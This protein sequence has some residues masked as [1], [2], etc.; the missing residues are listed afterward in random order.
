MLRE[1]DL[2]VSID[3]P[4]VDRLVPNDAVSIDI[5]ISNK[6]ETSADST[7]IAGAFSDSLS[8]VRWTRTVTQ[9]SKYPASFTL[10]ELGPDSGER[11]TAVNDKEFREPPFNITDSQNPKSEFLTVRV[12]DLNNDGLE[13]L[14]AQNMNAAYPRNGVVVFRSA[15]EPVE[16]DVA[17]IDGNNGF[18]TSGGFQDHAAVGDVNGDSIDDIVFGRAFNFDSGPISVVF[19]RNGAFPATVDLANIDQTIG[20]EVDP[21]WFMDRWAGTLGAPGDVNGDGVN[22]ILVGADADIPAEP[23]QS[24]ASVI[25]GRADGEFETVEQVDFY[26]T[27]SGSG[28][29][30]NPAGDI[31]ADGID[32]FVIGGSNVSYVLFGSRK[33]LDH[34]SSLDALDG[35]RGFRIDHRRE[36]HQAG[37]RGIG[38][39]NDD[40]FDDLFI[41]HID[42]AWYGLT[43]TVFE[44]GI[45]D[46]HDTLDIGIDSTVTYSITGRVR[47]DIDE[48]T[49]TF[50]AAAAPFRTDTDPS[51]NA[52]SKAV[53]VVTP[54]AGDVDLDGMVTFS[55]LLVL[56]NNFGSEALWTGG[57]LDHDGIVAFGDLLILVNNFGTTANN[58]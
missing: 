47:P 34:D 6:G 1:V 29:Y 48:L 16:F 49:T 50:S 23:L 38:D 43:D 31:N 18:W 40:G 57:D 55:N 14:L 5:S 36:W 53:N 10:S 37:I 44:T 22:D 2:E 9:S 21:P 24:G 35:T 42:F 3:L 4:D 54:I 19:G 39:V 51:N 26:R 56:A 45:G 7:S 25:L 32:D 13:D 12:G 46:I 11:K 52:V 15:E 33:I 17:T 28:R 58:T 8:D 20:F 30:L 27:F 41:P